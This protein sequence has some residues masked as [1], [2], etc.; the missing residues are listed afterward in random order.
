MRVWAG[1]GPPGVFIDTCRAPV[2]IPHHAQVLSQC[3]GQ[4]HRHGPHVVILGVKKME[5]K[6]STPLQ[7]AQGSSPSHPLCLQFPTPAMPHTAH[8]IHTPTPG[9]G[10]DAP[11]VG[12]PATGAL[13][14]PAP[15]EEKDVRRTSW[16]PSVASR[17]EGETGEPPTP[18]PFLGEVSIALYVNLR[19]LRE[20]LSPLRFHLPTSQVPI[21]SSLIAGTFYQVSP[22]LQGAGSLRKGCWDRLKGEEGT[23]GR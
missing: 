20:A 17:T 19:S 6:M 14:S 15:G 3:L 7:K 16:P 2:F 11:H 4:G 1:C 18:E 8:L 12:S 23:K 21:R 22:P 5:Q 10:A 13:E 9:Q